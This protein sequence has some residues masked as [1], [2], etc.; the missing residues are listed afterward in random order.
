M[1]ACCLAAKLPSS[2]STFFT[3]AQRFDDIAPQVA[4]T[5]IQGGRLEVP[6]RLALPGPD[7]PSFVGLDGYCELM[8]WVVWSSRGDGAGLPGLGGPLCKAWPT[9]RGWRFSIATA[10]GNVPLFLL[11]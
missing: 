10:C 1:V 2:A 5:V 7:T 9:H 11:P 3:N 6:A 8:R 4:Q